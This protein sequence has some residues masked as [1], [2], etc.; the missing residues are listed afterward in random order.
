MASAGTSYRRRVDIWLVGTVCGP[1]GS[2][3]APRVS[4]QCF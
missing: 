1:V 3:D 2:N 4:G